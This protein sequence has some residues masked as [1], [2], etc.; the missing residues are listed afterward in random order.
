MESRWGSYGESRSYSYREPR[1]S[2]SGK[3][4]G[5]SLES[6]SESKSR[7]SRIAKLKEEL[8]ALKREII[9]EKELKE[10]QEE[11]ALL[12]EISEARQELDNLRNGSQKR[13]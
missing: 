13:R 6:S 3:S 2:V 8:A 1:R 4:R 9:Q 10:R 12:A 7:S 5:E 11:E